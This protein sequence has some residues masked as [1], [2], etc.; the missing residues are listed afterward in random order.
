MG[1]IEIPS[2]VRDF[3]FQNLDSVE[4]LEILLL[5]HSEP[6]KTWSIDAISD[7]LRS[8]PNSVRTRLKLLLEQRHVLLEKDLNTYQYQ[9]RDPAA[10]TALDLLSQIYK[11]HKYRI[12]EIIFSPLKKSRDFA[13][14][15]KI[16]GKGPKGEGNG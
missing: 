14:A 3:V 15:F 9:L 13:D 7:Q 5:L 6:S 10:G 2:E 8:N 4:Q 11:V 1:E 12:L 16:G